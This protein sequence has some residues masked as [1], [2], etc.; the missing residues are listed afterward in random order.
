MKRS[1]R[2]LAW[3]RLPFGRLLGLAF[4]A[5]LTLA[6]CGSGNSSTGTS[7]TTATTSGA[8]GAS[9]TV[10]LDSVP[11]TTIQQST[12]TIPVSTPPSTLP[13]DTTSTTVPAAP[14]T[15]VTVAPAPTQPA[16]SDAV[17]LDIERQLDE[18]DQLL[19]DLDAELN[20]D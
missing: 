18:I 3:P 17:V 1:S 6:A 5:A 13:L 19:N 8:S 7:A 2:H 9:T 16:V 14:T 4:G 15:V 11:A 10:V 12:T 20:S